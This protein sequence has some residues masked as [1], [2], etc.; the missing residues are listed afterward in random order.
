MMNSIAEPE[1]STSFDQQLAHERFLREGYLLIPDCIPADE[2]KVMR[3]HFDRLM[4]V[5]IAEARKTTPSPL[6]V[7]IKRIFEDDPVFESLMNY[8]VTFPL[9]REI[10]GDD[11]TLASAGQGDCRPPHT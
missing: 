5:R 4:A 6:H 7:E 11:V 8:P 9:V 2:L 1:I 3:E 10:I